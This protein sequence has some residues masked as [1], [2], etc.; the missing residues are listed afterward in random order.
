MKLTTAQQKFLAALAN[1]EKTS[2]TGRFRRVLRE[3]GLIKRDENGRDIL[4]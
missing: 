3:A 2:A 4:A 1:G